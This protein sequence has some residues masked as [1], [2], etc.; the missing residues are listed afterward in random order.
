MIGTTLLFPSIAI[1][2]A[3]A[4]PSLSDG[5][6]CIAKGKTDKGSRIYFYTSVIDDNTMQKKQPISVTIN[7]SI[8]GQMQP[9]G[10]ASTSYQGNNNYS[11]KSQAGSPISFSLSRDYSGIQIRHGGKTYTGICH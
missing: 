10:L 1:E 11:G 6:I 9:A 3:T 4:S 8:N 5:I 2:T 7:E